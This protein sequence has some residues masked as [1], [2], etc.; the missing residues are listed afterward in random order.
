MQ[1]TLES[2]DVCT[3]YFKM[4]YDKQINQRKNDTNTTN[5]NMSI[6]KDG[7][8]AMTPTVNDLGLGT[9]NMH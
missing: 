3:N 4:Q 8:K 7:K 2:G 5:Y 1:L 6:D 9:F